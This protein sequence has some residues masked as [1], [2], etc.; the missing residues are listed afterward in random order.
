M[1]GISKRFYDAA[2]TTSLAHLLGRRGLN[3]HCGLTVH[4]MDVCM[5]RWQTMETVD[6]RAVVA[7]GM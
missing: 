6:G 2:A 4:K 3:A 7:D 1:D 5:D